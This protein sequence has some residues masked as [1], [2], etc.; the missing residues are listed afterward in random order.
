M[1]LASL[2]LLT[3]KGRQNKHPVTCLLR[4]N[5]SQN[6][7]ACSIVNESSVPCRYSGLAFLQP[8]PAASQWSWFPFL[9]STFVPGRLLSARPSFV[10][11]VFSNGFLSSP[12]PYEAGTCWS[13]DMGCNQRASSGPCISNTAFISLSCSVWTKG[14]I[15]SSYAK[16]AQSCPS[17]A[18]QQ[19]RLWKLMLKILLASVNMSYRLIWWPL[20]LMSLKSISGTWII[21]PR[22]WL[23]E[24]RRRYEIGIC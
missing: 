5:S 21:L 2:N 3:G 22:R 14:Y 6:Q 17:D 16:L 12:G 13:T 9:N 8:P 1:A 24:W 15:L 11:C 20:V 23:Q 10:H 19:L 4:Q 7:Q 18:S